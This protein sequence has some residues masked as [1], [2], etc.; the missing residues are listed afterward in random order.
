MPDAWWRNLN[1]RQRKPMGVHLA[2]RTHS[3]SLMSGASSLMNH[4]FSRRI[5]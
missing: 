2:K 4:L 3:F 1:A 5:P